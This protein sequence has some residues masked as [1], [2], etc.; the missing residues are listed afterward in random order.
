MTATATSAKKASDIK[1]GDR[2]P[3]GYVAAVTGYM[4][5]LADGTVSASSE[6]ITL[7]FRTKPFSPTGKIRGADNGTFDIRPGEDFAIISA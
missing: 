1:V 2:T 5:Q 4:R 6:Y 3:L 7:Y